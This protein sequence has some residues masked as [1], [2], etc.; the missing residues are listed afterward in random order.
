M[1]VSLCGDARVDPLADCRACDL[2]G[3]AVVAAVR[4]PDDQRVACPPPGPVHGHVGHVRS[5]MDLSLERA[6]AAAARSRGERAPQADALA[7]VRKRLAAHDADDPPDLTAARRRVA[8]ADADVTAL[9]ERVARLGGRVEERRAA[10]GDVEA[11]EAE[12]ADATR[13]LSEAETERV[14]AEQSLDRARRTARERRDARERRLSLR[15]RRDNLR[16]AAREHLVGTVAGAFR[17][18]TAAVPGAPVAA[19]G[20]YGGPPAL[21]ALAVARVASIDAPVVV[22]GPGLAAA[23]AVEGP[24]IVL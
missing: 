7:A 19:P 12:L 24:A 17:T 6:L 2:A 18:A 1:R 20:E 11:L 16:A 13:E 8:A 23:R 15:D 21:A 9:R 5:G 22:E 14:A 4:D 3:A 10:G